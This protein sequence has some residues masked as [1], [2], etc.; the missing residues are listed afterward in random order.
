MRAGNL[1]IKCIAPVQKYISIP[2]LQALTGQKV[3]FPFY[4]L[5]SDDNPAHIKHLYEVKTSI[6]FIKDLDLL[7]KYYDPM[8][9]DDVIQ[10]GKMG[11]KTKKP[12]FFLS[13]DDGLSSFYDIVC[14]ILIRK[15]IPA[16]CFV[17]TAFVDNKDLFFRY[18]ASLLIEYFQNNPS[19]AKIKAVV[20]WKNSK[21]EKTLKGAILS[22]KYEEKEQ[23]DILANIVGINFNTFLNENKPDL[24]TPQII[25][26]QDQGFYFGAH[27][28]DHPL[29]KNLSEKEQVRQTTLSINFVQHRLGPIYK[30][31]SFPFSDA[32]VNESYFNHFRELDASFGTAGLKMDEIQNHFQR[33]P[34]ENSGYTGE[35]LIK[36]AYIQFMLQSLL[37]KNNVMHHA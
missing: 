28:I 1:I 17:N 7:L 13:F 18:K 31:F 8:T 10:Y 20:S 16:A 14:P 37:G 19:S 35:T 3:I 36:S 24:T 9:L 33:I 23:I 4:H 21:N 27:S 15:G 32:G 26:L 34:M 12:G 30:I 25:E 11:K 29:Y 2:K 22:I 6:A 5:V